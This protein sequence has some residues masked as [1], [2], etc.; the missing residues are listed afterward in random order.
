[1][2]AFDGTGPRGQGPMTGRGLGSCGGGRGM[3]MGFGRCRGYGRGLGGYFGWG[4]PQTQ[5]KEEK[6]QDIKTY[7]KSLQEEVEDL[8]KEL[9]ALQ[10]QE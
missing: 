4:A 1:M 8:E 3:R 5:T 2:P 10:K 7:R 9:T 6:I